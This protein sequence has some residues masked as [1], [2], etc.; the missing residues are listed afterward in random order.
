MKSILLRPL[1]S[2]RRRAARH[3]FTLVEMLVSTALV[4]LIMVLFAQI[5]AAAVQTMRDQEG[6]AKNDQ[7]ARAA[8]I[9]IRNDL[10]NRTFRQV[11]NGSRGIVPLSSTVPVDFYQRGFF[12]YSENEPLDDRDDVL[13]F[14]VMYNDGTRFFGPFQNGEDF[15]ND[16]VGIDANQNMTIATTTTR[17]DN[18]PEF[19]D[20]I[21][22]NR[23]TASRAAVV[24]YF[25][26]QG[27]LYRRVNLLRDPHVRPTSGGFQVQPVSPTLASQSNAA[28]FPRSMVFNAQILPKWYNYNSIAMLPNDPDTGN[29]YLVGVQSLSNHRGTGRDSLGMPSNRWGHNSTG[30]PTSEY[31]TTTS[32]FQGRPL[33]DELR[34]GE[35]ALL[36]NVHAFD[37]KV[38]EQMDSSNTP[39][40]PSRRG[41]TLNVGKFV[42]LG[43]NDTSGTPYVGPYTQTKPTSGNSSWGRQNVGYGPN[44]S[45]G[46]NRVYDTW[47]PDR[48][49]L[50]PYCPK[51]FHT[52]GSRIQQ[53]SGWSAGGT[54]TWHAN[55]AERTIF[56]SAD[57]SLGWWPVSSGEDRDGN[58]SL[59]AAE[60]ANSN[61]ILDNGEDTNGNGQ[62]DAGEDADGDSMLDHQTTL[63]TNAPS[64]PMTPG[65]V[66][67][68]DT[69]VCWECF[70]NRLGLTLMRI[71]VRFTDPG[72][73][74]LRQVTIDHSFVEDRP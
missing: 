74:T 9:V 33:L 4:L 42:D 40:D 8:D 65:D 27:T 34:I 19:D 30:N 64:F 1:T 17:G 15:L 26:N 35:D 16:G 5:Y 29:F 50:A 13:S 49:D 70:D 52:D 36:T 58:G 73:Q 68:D 46:T 22:N 48:N 69:G 66:V 47:H 56:L 7:K 37:V 18:H 60:D 32:T 39:V 54:I 53:A 51:R 43:Y 31:N 41:Q 67:V 44:V 12:Y 24:T 71:T 45:G 21:V 72:S 20:G 59:G 57:R 28:L 14:T 3:G 6:I 62:L 25:V 38:W 23:Q 10:I 61:G 55:L 11:S 63:G 2:R